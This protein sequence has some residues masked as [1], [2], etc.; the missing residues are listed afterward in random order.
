[1]CVMAASGHNIGTEG[2][3]LVSVCNKC[4]GLDMYAHLDRRYGC[5]ESKELGLYYKGYVYVL[6]DSV[7]TYYTHMKSELK[8]KGA[9]TW[10][11]ITHP[12]TMQKM[13]K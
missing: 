13:P 2:G 9:G 1:M 5:Q 3:A 6:N 8:G 11:R 10:R 12:G 7:Y 4:A